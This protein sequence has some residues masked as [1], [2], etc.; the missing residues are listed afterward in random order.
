MKIILITDTYSDATEKAAAEASALVLS[1][2][3]AT[4]GAYYAPPSDIKADGDVEIQESKPIGAANRRLFV[5]GN[6]A[7]TMSFT[8]RPKFAS[9]E[10]AAAAVFIIQARVGTSGQLVI[11][12]SPEA[13][14]TPALV[15][16]P[17][18]MSTDTP[19]APQ[20]VWTGERRAAIKHVSVAQVGVTVEA[21]YDLEW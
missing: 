21:T 6:R 15:F 1:S 4:T 8:V 3:S 9:L 14:A 16:P 10:A 12:P 11:T 20:P 13:T 18:P 17:Y 7:G 19:P 5:R 2:N